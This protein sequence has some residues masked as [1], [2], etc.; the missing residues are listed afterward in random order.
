MKRNNAASKITNTKKPI[1]LSGTAFKKPNKNRKNHSGKILSLV[2]N[3][4]TIIH[5]SSWKT[6]Y[7]LINTKY[8][9]HNKIENERNKSRK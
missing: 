6:K 1:S 7:Q 2:F 3:V 9:T 8:I 5:D 4:S